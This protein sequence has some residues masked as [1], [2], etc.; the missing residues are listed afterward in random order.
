MPVSYKK[1]RYLFVFAELFFKVENGLSWTL[2]WLVPILDCSPLQSCPILWKVLVYIVQFFEISC[3]GSTSSSTLSKILYSSNPVLIPVICVIVAVLKE[4]S[5]SVI[6]RSNQR[7]FFAR[8]CFFILC[9][10]SAARPTYC[11][12]SSRSEYCS[13]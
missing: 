6:P 12:Q 1:H 8:S 13:L 7:I 4:H 3:F 9:G 11:P 2:E 5:L 10:S